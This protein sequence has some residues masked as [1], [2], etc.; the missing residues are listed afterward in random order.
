MD[1]FEEFE[2]RPLTEGLGFHGSAPNSGPSS[3]PN[4]GKPSSPASTVASSFN[5][6]ISPA[7]AHSNSHEKK[8]IEKPMDLPALKSPLPRKKS[9]KAKEE[10]KSDKIESVLQS[11]KTRNLDFMEARDPVLDAPATAINYDVSAVLL[12]SMLLIASFLTCLI[13]LLLVTHVDLVTNLAKEDTSTTLILSL[14]GLFGALSWSYLV[15]TRV[16]MGATP[17]EWVF[18]QTMGRKDQFGTLSFAL[19]VVART[20]V[21]VATGLIVFPIVSMVIGRDL[22]GHWLGLELHKV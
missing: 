16:F 10:K 9:E 18:D 7:G 8:S 21:L 17:G 11:I 22:L 1:P 2:F 13:I 5:S 19:L 3:A 12:D 14:A 15:L 6:E 4:S 20:T